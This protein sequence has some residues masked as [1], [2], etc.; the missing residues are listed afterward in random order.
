MILFV[1]VQAL[2]THS[3]CGARKRLTLNSMKGRS[4]SFSRLW[5]NEQ[6]GEASEDNHDFFVEAFAAEPAKAKPKA[7]PVIEEEIPASPVFALETVRTGKGDE[8]V[9]RKALA[10]DMPRVIPPGTVG[11]NKD[12]LLWCQMRDDEIDE[13]VVKFNSGRICFATSRN[14]LTNWKFD[15]DSP[16]MGPNKENGDWFYFDA[17]HIGLGDVI[18]PGDRAQQK[19]NTMGGVFLMYIFGGRNEIEEIGDEETK[20]AV[21]GSKL[22][23]GVAVSQDGAHWSRVEG[24]SPFG[25]IVEFGKEGEFDHA[26]AGWPSVIEISNDYRMYYHTY[27]RKDGMFKVGYA[28]ASDGLMTWK[29]KGLV[30][31]GS[32]SGDFDRRGATKRHVVNL[33]DG[34][35]KMWYEGISDDGEHSI[36]IATS[37]DGVKWTAKPDPVFTANKEDSQAWDSGGVGSPHL[38]WIPQRKIWRMYYSGSSSS[39]GGHHD[40]TGELGRLFA[41]NIGVAESLDEEGE[42][43][44]RL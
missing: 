27:D 17:E 25:G 18:Q 31:A 8:I 21:K 26:Y 3:R 41:T 35:Y 44:V 38:V 13:D 7:E 37:L 19:F 36:G 10:I 15:I 2:S 4:S 14:G 1:H 39:E 34:T 32:T 22:E 5:M 28:V 42:S 12:W 24:P 23:I 40:D 9:T 11:D 6:N 30:F 20:I 43:W 29:K 16:I 33:P